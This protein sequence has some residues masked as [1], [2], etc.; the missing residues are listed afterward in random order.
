MKSIVVAPSIL[1]VDLRQ[2]G[3]EVRAIDPTDADWMHIDI[4][5]GRFVLNISFGPAIVVA[6]P[7][8]RS[9]CT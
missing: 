2:L 8:S 4:M 9:M 6:R 5:D 1:A 3:A 7:P